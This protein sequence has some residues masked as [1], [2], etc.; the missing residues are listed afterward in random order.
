[1]IKLYEP[2]YFR[3]VAEFESKI[4]MW[5]WLMNN[6]KSFLRLKYIFN[7]DVIVHRDDNTT[8]YFV[9]ETT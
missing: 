4:S 5:K 7:N 3:E 1:M 6:A 2:E 9:E 8:V